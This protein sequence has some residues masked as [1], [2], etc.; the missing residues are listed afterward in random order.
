MRWTKFISDLPNELILNILSFSFSLSDLQHVR[1]QSRRF[2]ANAD[3][4]LKILYRG[5]ASAAAVVD[6]PTSTAPMMERI[7]KLRR[8]EAS[9]CHFS[10]RE[11]DIHTL[12]NVNRPGGGIAS[13]DILDLNGG[14]LLISSPSRT[15]SRRVSPTGIFYTRLPSL[16]HMESVVWQR[17]PFTRD[18]KEI[19]KA[20]RLVAE[21]DLLVI[22]TLW[23][24]LSYSDYDHTKHDPIGRPVRKT[25]TT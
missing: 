25:R 3:A 7:A 1:L 8:W 4:A 22:V 11:I 15:R 16:H 6:D 21:L 24:A 13:S 14:F 10:G 19:I 2:R 18:P 9:F 20:F 23:V 17:V 12:G 5:E